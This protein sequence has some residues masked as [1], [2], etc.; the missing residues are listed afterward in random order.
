MD[1]HVENQESHEAAEIPTVLGPAPV[2]TPIEN[3]T[4]Q[5]NIVVA[6]ESEATMFEADD[7]EDMNAIP[8]TVEAQIQALLF[9][10]SEPVPLAK[11]ASLLN[12]SETEITAAI[13]ILTQHCLQTTSGLT[14]STVAGGYQ[15]RTKPEMAE[16]MKQFRS[17]R[18]RRL[19]MAALETLAIIAYRQPVV[20][21][22]VEK[23][24]GVD[25]APTLK[26]LLDRG[27]IKIVGHAST[28]GQPALFA[29]ADEFLK[30]FGLNSLTELPTLRDLR[31]IDAAKSDEDTALVHED[32]P[33][34]EAA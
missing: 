27:L 9:G 1:N 30:V 8:L 14:L 34:A 15:F 10:A 33:S 21:S 6:V 19:S 20:R 4:E 28:P 23:L 3:L 16:V 7:T 32:E 25:I 26:T 17:G 11:I 13:E 2:E 29:T 31:D 22:D 5:D 12:K 24:R 18:P